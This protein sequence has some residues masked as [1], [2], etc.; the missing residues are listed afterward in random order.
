MQPHLSAEVPVPGNRYVTQRQLHTRGRER[1]RERKR[2]RGRER[3]RLSVRN[4]SGRSRYV[5]PTPPI[6]YAAK[7]FKIRDEVAP[8]YDEAMLLT[9]C[10]ELA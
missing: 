8:R 7:P 3:Q 1:Q 10:P 5:L 9:R 4:L 6:P 2:E